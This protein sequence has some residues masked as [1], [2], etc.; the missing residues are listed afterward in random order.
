MTDGPLL[1]SVPAP[2]SQ[3]EKRLLAS[4]SP[5]EPETTATL[6]QGDGKLEPQTL[7]LHWSGPNLSIWG[8]HS[9]TQVPLCS[10]V[11]ASSLHPFAGEE[12]ARFVLRKG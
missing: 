2:C 5:K 3:M 12:A 9:E 11:L 7:I 1:A 8:E 6:F 10:L 4:P